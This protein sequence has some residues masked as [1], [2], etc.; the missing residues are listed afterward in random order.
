[1][2]NPG[3]SARGFCVLPGNHEENEENEGSH[4]CHRE[5]QELL[6]EA[7]PE[8]MDRKHDDN[9]DEDS[10]PEITPKREYAHPHPP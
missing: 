5:G 1:M 3:L 6:H 9:S 10:I 4:R 2:K 7:D 8:K